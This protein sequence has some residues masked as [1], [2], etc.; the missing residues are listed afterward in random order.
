MIHGAEASLAHVMRMLE[1]GALISLN[2]KRIAV[3]ID[4]I[5]VHGDGPEAVPTARALRQGLEEA[6]YA[7]RTLPQVLSAR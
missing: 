1:E 5:C 3:S 7:V 2:G 4:S 6:G